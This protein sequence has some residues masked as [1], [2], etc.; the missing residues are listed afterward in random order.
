ML[1]I[2]I[3][4]L[5]MTHYQKKNKNDG[6]KTTDLRKF[7]K[8]NVFFLEIHFWMFNRK[9]MIKIILMAGERYNFYFSL[10]RGLTISDTRYTSFF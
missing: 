6:C 3:N 7:N 4:N 1:G 8:R 2:V 9:D 5:V 10:K